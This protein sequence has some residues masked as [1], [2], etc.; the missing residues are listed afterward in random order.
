MLNVAEDIAASDLPDLNRWA[1]RD[2]RR[3]WRCMSCSGPFHHGSSTMIPHRA[4]RRTPASRLWQVVTEIELIEWV[5]GPVRIKVS[6]RRSRRMHHLRFIVDDLQTQTGPLGCMKRRR[7]ASVRAWQ[8]PILKGRVIHWSSSFSKTGVARL[9]ATN[10][11][12]LKASVYA[13]ENHRWLMLCH[14]SGPRRLR[15]VI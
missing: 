10:S 9:T 12:L 5:S 3:R 6:G 14:T 8:W 4:R 7:S 1:S 15:R 2:Y 11:L 13:W